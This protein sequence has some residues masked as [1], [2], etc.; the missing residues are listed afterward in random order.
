MI[1]GRAEPGGD[2]A[3]RRHFVFPF[4]SFFEGGER[5]RDFLGSCIL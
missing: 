1:G 5:E 4:R 2:V 3:R